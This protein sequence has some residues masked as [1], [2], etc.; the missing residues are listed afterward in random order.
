[1]QA[2]QTDKAGK[3]QEG[4]APHTP[5][6]LQLPPASVTASK[7]YAAADAASRCAQVSGRPARRHAAPGGAGRHG[8]VRL[9][10]RPPVAGGVRVLG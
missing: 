7:D 3:R 1:M 2:G 10:V 5:S 8:Q 9:V 6:L 4:R